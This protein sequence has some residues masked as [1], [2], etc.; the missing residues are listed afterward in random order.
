MLL[1]DSAGACLRICPVSRQAILGIGGAVALVGV[2]ISAGAQ[3]GP[4]KVRDCTIALPAGCTRS[5]DGGTAADQS[6]AHVKEVEEPATV[7]S[8]TPSPDFQRSDETAYI[9]FSRRLPTTKDGMHYRSVTRTTPACAAS[10]IT[11]TAATSA[12]GRDIA[13]SIGRT[14]PPA[15]P[16][17][18]LQK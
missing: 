10:V 5:A 14:A 6:E 9:L 2:A 15:A 17:A 12:S 16:P 8:M 4:M 13:R 1:R 18:P 11:R 7:I 3:P